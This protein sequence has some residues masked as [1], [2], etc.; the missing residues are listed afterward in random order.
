MDYRS[1]GHVER[2]VLDVLV[3]QCQELRCVNVA[4]KA[5]PQRVRP[6]T[7]FILNGETNIDPKIAR[8]PSKQRW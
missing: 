8:R 2:T 1:H 7:N 3:E 5:S 4:R 6:S